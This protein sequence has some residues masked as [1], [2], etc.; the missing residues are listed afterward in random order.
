[1]AKNNKM[2]QLNNNRVNILLRGGAWMSQDLF[3][4]IKREGPAT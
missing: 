4:K 2:P 1:M 3:S